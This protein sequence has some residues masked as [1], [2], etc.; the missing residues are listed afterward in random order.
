MSA[1]GGE[2]EGG[3][4]KSRCSKG[5]CVNLILRIGLKCRQGAGGR[6]SKIPKILQSS[7]VHAP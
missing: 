6:G 4:L 1:V 3:Y 2:G 7:Y 5:G